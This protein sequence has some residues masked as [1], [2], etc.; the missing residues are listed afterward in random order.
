MAD[1]QLKYRT[2]NVLN[3]RITCFYSYFF[4]S[5]FVFRNSNL[6]KSK[7]RWGEPVNKRPKREGEG[8]VEGERRG[9]TTWFANILRMITSERGGTIYRVPSF[10]GGEEDWGQCYAGQ[11]PRQISANGGDLAVA[12]GAFHDIFFS[13]R[14]RLEEHWICFT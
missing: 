4:K 6:Y 2:M 13:R 3:V 1:S 10:Y 11:W 9:E 5:A 8:R 12:F 14:T 7:T